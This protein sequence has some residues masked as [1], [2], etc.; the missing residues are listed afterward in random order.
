MQFHLLLLAISVLI[1]LSTKESYM[2]KLLTTN[3][4]DDFSNKFDIRRIRSIDD[5]HGVIQHMKKLKM[6]IPANADE[7]VIELAHAF[8]DGKKI[9][10][11]FMGMNISTLVKIKNDPDM[12]IIQKK[13]DLYKNIAKMLLAKTILLIR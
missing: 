2:T 5:I 12:K 4:I 9:E 13:T 1:A 11:I 10:T 6:P 8:P 7:T 3:D